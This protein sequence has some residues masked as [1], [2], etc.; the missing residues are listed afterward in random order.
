MASIRQNKVSSLLQ[1]ELATFFQ[2]E[3]KTYFGG[4]LI[5][6]TVVRV[7]SDLS[8]AKVYLSIFARENREEI[9]RFVDS[10]TA[11]IRY[12]LGKVIGKQL[13]II[14]ELHFYYDDSLDYAEKIDNLLK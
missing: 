10:Q 2:R 7:S 6:V 8:V 14:P 5:S 11:Q 4:A 3:S 12:H 9:F 13:R 1:K